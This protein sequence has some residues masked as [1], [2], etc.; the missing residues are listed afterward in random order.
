ML[1]NSL[2]YI[3]D[4]KVLHMRERV[5]IHEYILN[6]FVNRYI[7]NYGKLPTHGDQNIR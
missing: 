6:A 2:H 3:R 5:N 1:Q 4:K 7:Q